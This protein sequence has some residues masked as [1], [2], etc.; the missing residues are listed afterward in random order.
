[1][2]D[3]IIQFFREGPTI[4][5]GPCADLVI[6]IAKIHS[7]CD[8]DSP[9]RLSNRLLAHFT[10]LSG[11]GDWSLHGLPQR[12]TKLVLAHQM[13][14]LDTSERLNNRA[15][16]DPSSRLVRTS[17][18]PCVMN[19]D[20]SCCPSEMSEHQVKCMLCEMKGKEGNISGR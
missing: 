19:D 5:D 1:M 14:D 13:H 4:V 6:L 17:C 20:I 8:V 10:R 18:Q 16:I 3:S 9:E 15:C 7:S 2:C 12:K 11:S